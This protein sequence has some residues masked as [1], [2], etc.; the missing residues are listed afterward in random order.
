MFCESSFKELPT[1]LVKITAIVTITV[2][3]MIIDTAFGILKSLAL[4]INGLQIIAIKTES[5]KGTNIFVA[6]LIPAKMI[7]IAATVTKALAIEL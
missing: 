5:K 7:K 4:L 2:I 6:V 3:T 1:K